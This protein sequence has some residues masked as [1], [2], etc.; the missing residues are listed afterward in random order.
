MCAQ[1]VVEE[2][3]RGG[4]A[5]FDTSQEVENLSDEESAERI[6]RHFATIS[7][8]YPPLDISS[9]QERVQTKLEHVESPPAVSDYDAYRQIRAG[10]RTMT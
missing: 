3:D 5:Y 1:G 9:L 4:V 2:I 7:Q 8:E 6:A 10:R